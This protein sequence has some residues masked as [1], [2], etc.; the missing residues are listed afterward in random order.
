VDSAIDARIARVLEAMERQMADPLT[1]CDLAAIAGLSP[2]RFAHLFRRS[3]GVSPL[4]H[5]HTLRMTRAQQLLEA[6]S[7]PIRDVMRQVGWKDPS[8]FSKDFKRRFGVAPRR[9]R[10]EFDGSADADL[11]RAMK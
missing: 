10:G 2:S 4:R 6:S 11:R 8:H 5:L 3:V 1:V 7:L 9:Y